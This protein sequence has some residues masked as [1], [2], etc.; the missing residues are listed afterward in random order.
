MRKSIE[1]CSQHVDKSQNDRGGN[2]Q[3]NEVHQ[4]CA[5]SSDSSFFD[6]VYVSDRTHVRSGAN[7]G[8]VQTEL[9]LVN[10]LLRFV[11]RRHLR[12]SGN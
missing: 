1:L 7:A 9:A 4:W 11:P 2:W 10:L 8:M 6:S 12:R 3:K 5:N